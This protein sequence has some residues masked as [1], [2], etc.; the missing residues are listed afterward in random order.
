VV[1]LKTFENLVYGGMIQCLGYGLT[2]KAGDGPADRQNV[3]RQLHDYKVPGALDIP[4]NHDIVPTILKTMN[5]ITS[6]ARDWAS[7]RMF[8]GCRDR[9]CC[10]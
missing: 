10:L 3:Q 4:L 5:A 8:H 9:Q 2:E 6:A 1:N 7:L